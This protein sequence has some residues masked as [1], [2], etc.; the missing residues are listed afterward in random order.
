MTNAA[1]TKLLQKTA[2]A[3]NRYDA[4]YERARNEYVRRYGAA[5]GEHDNDQW[6]DSIEGGCGRAFEGITTEDVDQ[7]AT[8]SGMEP[9][10]P[11]PSASG[12]D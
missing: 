10:H 11:S 2:R 6:I 4:L 8:D 3:Y 5:P 12:I 1:F 9:Y 7:W